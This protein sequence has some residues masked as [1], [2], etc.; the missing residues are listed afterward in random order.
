MANVRCPMCGKPNPAEAETCQFCRARIKPVVSGEKTAGK[1]AEPKLPQS[2]WLRELRGGKS[3]DAA[4]PSLRDSLVGGSS[5]APYEEESTDGLLGDAPDWLG[6]LGSDSGGTNEPDLR[7]AGQG[8]NRILGDSQPAEQSPWMTGMERTPPV[9][10]PDSADDDFGWLNN[11]ALENVTPGDSPVPVPTPA[12]T[13]SPP[14]DPVAPPARPAENIP[15]WLSSLGSGAV[16]SFTQQTQGEELSWL[17]E[18]GLPSQPAATGP[19]AADT[20]PSLQS[21]AGA[22]QAEAPGNLEAGAENPWENDLTSWLSQA[23]TDAPVPLIE[24]GASASAPGQDDSAW[25]SWLASVSPEIEPSPVD[26]I[27]PKSPAPVS[28]APESA[29]ESPA[30]EV[31]Q[32]DVPAWLKA[33]APTGSLQLSEVEDVQTG[34]PAPTEV[35]AAAQPG[36]ANEIPGTAEPSVETGRPGLDW[37]SS[38]NLEAAPPESQPDTQVSQGLGWLGSLET[39]VSGDRLLPEDS[40]ADRPD[41][42]AR[43]QEGQLQPPAEALPVTRPFQDFPEQLQAEGP[44]KPFST[45]NMPDWLAR[46]VPSETE[47]EERGGT[48]TQRDDE[49][50]LEPADLPAWVQAMRPIEAA[51]PQAP[52]EVKGEVDERVESLGP[53]AGLRGVLPVDQA[54]GDVQRP[55]VFSVKL[56][57]TEKQQANVA[58]LEKLI[59]A[60]AGPAPAAAGRALPIQRILRVV[61]ALLLLVSVAFPIIS[62]GLNLPVPGY[63]PQDVL[64]LQGAIASLPAD[65]PVLL[66]VEYEPALA[67]ELESAASGMMAQLMAHSAR[68]VVVSTNPTGQALGSRLLQAA[69]K[70]QPGYGLEQKTVELGFLAGGPAGLF[71]FMISP[72]LA[73]PLD[74]AL[75]PAWAAERGNIT[76]IRDFAMLIVIT[77]NSETARYW[78]EQVQ[79]GIEKVPMFMVVSAQAAP[80]VAPYVDSGQV[81]AMVTG[82]SGGAIYDQ[83]AGRTSANRSSWDAYQTGLLAALVMIM[84]GGL[85]NV[86][87]VGFAG[88]KT[89]EEV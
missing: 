6:R 35:P 72:Q 83:A 88:R 24:T 76:S 33:S 77:E 27:L 79:P 70:E 14:P 66:A 25:A 34:S 28:P 7:S 52:V 12:P 26:A 37:L 16:D 21:A 49:I 85:A 13:V 31:V 5:S 17:Q 30:E 8:L 61:I 69:V 20:T 40:P 45:D 87:W 73:V 29:P 80:M 55:A 15:D 84:F 47:P 43:M 81:K 53:L 3:D 41:W 56:H 67:G 48:G 68:I 59:T 32:W 39:A 2:D 54:G 89:K 78:V 58:L 38:L 86:I 19:A 82:L 22:N 23:E 50:S 44:V 9:S 10:S 46:M 36:A 71:T 57:V 42:L 11:L 4:E 63:L 64:T 65:A 1:P 18:L 74:T 51:T 62:G 75:R 60:E